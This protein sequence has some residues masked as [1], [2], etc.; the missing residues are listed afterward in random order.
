[1]ESVSVSLDDLEVAEERAIG[2][3]AI[4]QY[5]FPEIP[6]GTYRVFF[7]DDTYQDVIAQNASHAYQLA[8]RPDIARLI[9]LKFAY[10]H[11]LERDVIHASGAEVKPSLQ[12]YED[13]AET[14]LAELSTPDTEPFE[15]MDL[16]MFAALGKLK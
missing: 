8:D 16:G 15:R 7:S 14:L 6:S 13:T 4:R 1:M 2:E 3:I 5:R 11:I 9:N 12:G 10:S